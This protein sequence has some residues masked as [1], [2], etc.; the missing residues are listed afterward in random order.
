MTDQSEAIA[1]EIEAIAAEGNTEQ[2]AASE[3]PQTM[4]DRL[5]S[6]PGEELASQ[7]L[8]ITFG[9]LERIRGPHWSADPIVMQ[10]AARE[11]GVL[12][13]RMGGKINLP[14]WAG[15]A[16]ISGLLL[17]KPV[18]GELALKKAREEAEQAKDCLLYT[19]P[20]PR[21]RG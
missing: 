20:S 9:T 21:D 13:D 19:S 12:I 2:A 17:F 11:Y 15:M 8:N 7:F 3:Q 4:Q 16:V 10:E 18:A 1:A 5:E 14:P 6:M